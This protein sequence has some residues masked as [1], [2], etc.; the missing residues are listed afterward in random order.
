M[1]GWGF[2]DNFDKVQIYAHEQMH[3][4]RERNGQHEDQ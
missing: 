3:S 2:A 1:T 4:V